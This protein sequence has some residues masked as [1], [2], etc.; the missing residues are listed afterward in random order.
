MSGVIEETLLKF[1]EKEPEP[2]LSLLATV[3][4]IE[5]DKINVTLPGD[6]GIVTIRS[7]SDGLTVAVN[8]IVIIQ[9]VG[10]DWIIVHKIVDVGDN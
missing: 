9:K 10:F 7:I 4:T 1:M 8:D 2:V 6:T 3:S 5:S